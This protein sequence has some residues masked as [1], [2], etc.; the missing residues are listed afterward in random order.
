[1]LG[2]SSG[3]LPG[4]RKHLPELGEHLP[5]F[6]EHIPEHGENGFESGNALLE[7]QEMLPVLVDND[8]GSE[9]DVLE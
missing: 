3:D 9:M 4:K 8:S 5:Q 6:S 1:M 2:D 7:L